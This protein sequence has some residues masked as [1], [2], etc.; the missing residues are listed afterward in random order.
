MLERIKTWVPLL[1][2]GANVRNNKTIYENFFRGNVIQVFL[3]EGLFDFMKQERTK[4][5]IIEHFGYKEIQLVDQL[6]SVFVKDDILRADNG[7]YIVNYPLPETDV[8]IPFFSYS[9]QKLWRDYA[10]GIPDRFRGKHKDFT[11]GTNLFNWNDALQTR[12]YKLLRQSA[13][14]F[15]NITKRPAIFLDLGCGNGFGT[16]AIWYYYYKQNHF[17]ERNLRKMKIIGID[18]DIN[19]IRIAQEEFPIMLSQFVDLSKTELQALKDFFPT[20]QCGSAE[21]IPYAN[22]SFD[23]V[24]ASQVLHWTGGKKAIEEMIRVTKPNGLIFGST[25]LFPTASHYAN[26]H[27]LVLDGAYGYF[28][29]EELINW[30]EEAGAKN[31]QLST[32]ITNFKFQKRKN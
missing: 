2:I 4:E 11:G 7:Y 6:L 25:T 16:T 1:K 18:P 9:A 12:T 13:F 30:A 28:T 15:A 5:E 8:D 14:N 31:I 17:Q 23:V 19:L 20:F 29:K 24:Y 32:P 10:K 22:N 21:D 3:D 26:F 27:I